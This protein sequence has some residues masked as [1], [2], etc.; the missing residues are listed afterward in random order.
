MNDFVKIVPATQWMVDNIIA[1][2]LQ[3]RGVGCW[4]ITHGVFKGNKHLG[5]LSIGA[6]PLATLWLNEEAKVRDSHVVA[7]FIEN[8]VV[9]V[10]NQE[11]VIVLS[12][13]TCKLYPYLQRVGY[14]P[15]PYN[16]VY[17]KDLKFHE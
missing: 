7:Q 6:I 15:T 8:Y 2:S 13:P 10:L 1:K 12:E 11:N 9:S 14:E 5:Q 4:N 17:I 3:S 16:K